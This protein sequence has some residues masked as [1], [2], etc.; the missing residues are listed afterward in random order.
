MSVILVV[1]DEANV[2]KLVTINLATRGYEVT[3]AQTGEQTMAR[4]RERTPALMVLDIKL[5]DFSG[6]EILRRIDLDPLLSANFPVLVMT[7]SAIDAT[8]E[9]E[10][11]PSIVGILIKPFRT[12]KL[13]SAVHDA[14]LPSLDSEA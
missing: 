13:I 12:E 2:R 1:E 11:F 8:L 3:Q 6:W 10:E 9:L 14:L 7:A 4:L 5:P